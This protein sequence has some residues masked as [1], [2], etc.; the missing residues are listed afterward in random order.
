MKPL[1]AGLPVLV[2][3]AAIFTA[4]ASSI[5]PLTTKENVQTSA[6]IFRGTV[7]AMDCFKDERG[8][9]YTRT[10]LRVDEPFKGT[11][12]AVVQVVHRG[13]QVGD[14]NEFC[15]FSPRFQPG[16]EYLLFVERGADGRLHC[17][18]GAAGAHALQRDTHSIAGEFSAGDEALLDDV[19]A[20][21]DNGQMPG[22]DVTDQ[23]GQSGVIPMAT[24]GMLGNV[25]SRFLQP[26]RGEPIRYV[27]DADSLP[28]GITLAQATNALNQ[29]LGAWAAVTSLKFEF[30]GFQSFGQSADTLT[31]RDQML[32]IQLHDNYHSITDTNVL[33]FGGRVSVTSVL[34]G[35]GWDLG[36]NV[37]GNEFEQTTYGYVV[38]KSTQPAMQTLAT[39]AEVLCHEIG[40]ALNMAHSSEVVT[41]DPVLLNSIMYFQA[42]EDGRGATLGSYDPPVIQQAY[43]SNTV[44]FGYNRYFDATTAS[45]T[46]NVPGINEIE[47]R[48]YDLQ[49]TN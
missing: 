35:A 41:T 23:A 15:G 1:R 36:G 18:Q 30:A 24:T 16:G 38:L 12:P 34:N 47:L 33:G 26:D 43:P 10:S 48:G 28:A 22:D 45:T 19:R 37:A 42:H 8:L 14:E 49:T 2:L 20:L 25:N 6:A 7:T 11:F 46:P 44:P 13:G 17:T 5:I 29:A 39:F 32:H 21:T 40:H 4:S 3:L 9:I 31:N 27:V